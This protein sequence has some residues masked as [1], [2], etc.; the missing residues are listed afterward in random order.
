MSLRRTALAYGL[1]KEVLLVGRGWPDVIE[2]RSAAVLGEARAF[3]T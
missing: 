3:L 2:D 1:G